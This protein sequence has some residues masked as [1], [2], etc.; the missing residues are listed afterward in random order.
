MD[1]RPADVV[2]YGAEWCAYCHLAMDYLK[3][4][5]VEYRYVD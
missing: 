5:K 3:G 1:K 4:K 2:V